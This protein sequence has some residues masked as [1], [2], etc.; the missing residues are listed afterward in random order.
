M[1]LHAHPLTHPR[2]HDPGLCVAK[3]QPPPSTEVL[4]KVGSHSGRAPSAKPPEPGKIGSSVPRSQGLP[5][6]CG[7]RLREPSSEAGL[8]WVQ[9]LPNYDLSPWSLSFPV[10]RN[11]LMATP[12]SW[13]TPGSPLG[14]TG[15]QPSSVRALCT[16]FFFF[17]L[18]VCLLGITRSLPGQVV[19]GPQ[20]QQRPFALGAGKCK[21]GEPLCS[22]SRPLLGAAQS[23]SARGHPWLS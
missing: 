7:R 22:R 21:A 14:S 5:R 10:W 12:V 13:D 16:F 20:T 18:L 1:R 11:G 2:T 3:A 6:Q 15:I 23:P 17:P 9:I 19:G 4:W 8:G